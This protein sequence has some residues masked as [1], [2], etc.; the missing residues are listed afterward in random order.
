MMPGPLGARDLSSVHASTYNY[1]SE[2]GGPC[3]RDPIPLLHPLNSTC[4]SCNLVSSLLQHS[5]VPWWKAC[6]GLPP[7]MFAGAL[8]SM[9]SSFKLI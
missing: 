1:G 5:R 3:L 9:K 2:V 7:H 8:L 6:A 4:Y